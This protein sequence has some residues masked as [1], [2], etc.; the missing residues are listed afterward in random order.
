MDG[1]HSHKEILEAALGQSED[2][3]RTTVAMLAENAARCRRLASATHDRTAA[4]ILSAMALD[5]EQT[6]AALSR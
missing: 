6:A 1:C 5:Y 2:Q 4:G 3:R